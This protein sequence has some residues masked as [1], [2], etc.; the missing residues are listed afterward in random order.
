MEQRPLIRRTTS[1]LSRFVVVSLILALGGAVVFLLSQL[2]ART[3]RVE[4][5]DGNLVVVKG[6]MFPVG[7]EPYR[8]ADAAMKE[9]YAPIPLEGTGIG[10]LAEQ[11]FNDRDDLDRA[12]FDVLARLAT[13]RINSDDP[14]ALE[15][16]VYYLRRAERLSGLS[17]DQRLALKGMQTDAAYYLARSKLDDARRQ[18]ADALS[19]L[20]VAAGV[21]NRHS[22]SA[23]QMISEVEPAANAL[24]EAL[25]RAVH[26]LSSPPSSS[27]APSSEAAAPPPPRSTSSSPD[28]STPRPN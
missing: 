10:G 27:S 6:R 13:P 22:R 4:V 28:G 2:N 7:T 3:F 26:T 23:N 19:Q 11:R 8:P 17:E 14:Q 25:R 5:L 15:R 21:Q 24:E 9:A 12:L 20:K 18:I 1:A 16:G